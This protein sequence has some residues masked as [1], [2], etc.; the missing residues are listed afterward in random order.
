MGGVLL[1]EKLRANQ[2]VEFVLN[3]TVEEADQGNNPTVLLFEWQH[4][5][6]LS[7]ETMLLTSFVYYLRQNVKDDVVVPFA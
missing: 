5:N 4:G 1:L 7:S 2:D 6:D 3:L